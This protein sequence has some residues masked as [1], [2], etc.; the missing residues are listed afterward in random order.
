MKAYELLDSPEKWTQGSHA[1]SA[2]GD[3][4]GA[5]DAD[6][7]RWCIAGAFRKCYSDDFGLYTP[8]GLAAIKRVRGLVLENDL[9]SWNDD[10]NRTF[11]QV[12]E[13]LIKADA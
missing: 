7:C 4:R 8:E 9:V 12:R 3:E 13:A 6:A 1:R 2:S 5:N 10:P 11:E